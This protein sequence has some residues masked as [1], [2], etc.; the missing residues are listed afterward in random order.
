MKQKQEEIQ[1][2][3]FPSAGRDEK[4][5]AEETKNKRK[6]ETEGNQECVEIWKLK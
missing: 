4:E 2:L 6:G 1:G 3:T 5:Q